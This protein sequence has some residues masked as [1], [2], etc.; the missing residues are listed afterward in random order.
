MG[1]NTIALIIWL[2]LYNKKEVRYFDKSGI[3]SNPPTFLETWENKTI[4]FNFKGKIIR[5]GHLPFKETY[6]HISKISDLFKVLMAKHDGSMEDYFKDKR[7]S[8]MEITSVVDTIADTLYELSKPYLSFYE[9]LGR[10]K[11]MIKKCRN[12]VDFVIGLSG[13]IFDY[14]LNLGNAL[15]LLMRG[16]TV[17]MMYGQDASLNTTKRDS[18]G[19]R[20]IEPRQELSIYTSIMNQKLLKDS[21]SNN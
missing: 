13:E 12:D 16:A 7:L 20:L 4:N 5:I 10:R 14:W 1:L 19:A 6:N 17:K 8:D 11:W 18:V 21:P 9:R 2:Y 3:A 15:A